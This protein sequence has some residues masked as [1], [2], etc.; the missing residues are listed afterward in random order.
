MTYPFV[1][2]VTVQAPTA[3]DNPATKAYV[4]DAISN[5]DIGPT[6]PQP[7]THEAEDITADVLDIA[8]IPTGTTSTTV[9][10]GDHTHASG[11]IPNHAPS[12]AVG[13]SDP[14]TPAAIGAATSTHNHDT[15]YAPLNHNHDGA[16][17]TTGTINIARLPTGTGANNVVLGNDPRFGIK[18]YAVVTL[19]DAASMIINAALGN[20]F[21][22][23][24]N[25]N[26]PFGT[27]IN[28]TDGQIILLEMHNQTGSAFTLSFNAAFKAG[29]DFTL[30]P[31]LAGKAD[32]IQ[33]MYNANMAKWLL[34]G[35]SKGY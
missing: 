29:S 22:F 7:H 18:P 3:P 9:A 26:R 14:L 32:M 15:A 23:M 19:V 13:G 1:G 28:A 5:I 30:T 12:H 10:I 35:Y 2:P 21:R 20:H 33:W 31:L 8:R 17:I 34:I 16:A 27:P 25:Q 4:D 6:E 24:M 11:G